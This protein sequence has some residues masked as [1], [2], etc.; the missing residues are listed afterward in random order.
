MPNNPESVS[1]LSIG[2][3]IG[4]NRYSINNYMR[5][6]RKNNCRY[7]IPRKNQEIKA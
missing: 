1:F 7:K 6:K 4:N 2:R 5:Y 3:M